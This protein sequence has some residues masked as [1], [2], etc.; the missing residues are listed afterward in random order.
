MALWL[1]NI[2]EKKVTR[3]MT[4]RLSS[5]PPPPPN[6]IN[7]FKAGRHMRATTQPGQ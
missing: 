7:I 5:R 2:R 3:V 6:E 4:G 1:G